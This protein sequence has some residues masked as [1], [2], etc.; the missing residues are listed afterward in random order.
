MDYLMYCS[1]IPEDKQYYQKLTPDHKDIKSY[2]RLNEIRKDIDSW[3]IEGN[4]LYLHSA[5][6]GNGKTSW[7]IKLL[8]CY[9]DAVWD[10]TQF[11]C[12]GV[13]MSV[14]IFMRKYKNQYHRKDDFFEFTLDNLETA[15]LVVW[16]DIGAAGLNDNEF[17]TLMAYIE[18]RFLAGLSN[19]FTGNLSQEQLEAQ[20][21][22][23]LAQ[24][25]YVNSEALE[26]LGQ[27][28]R[29]I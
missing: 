27:C 4:S 12:R 15:E 20:C 26:F 5:N 1:R 28:N 29:G 8:K 2:K 9:F 22:K 23:R 21:G 7:A 14:P 25:L 3:V 11:R 18:Q 6:F 16:D 24:R 17:K 10:N 19:I 13:F